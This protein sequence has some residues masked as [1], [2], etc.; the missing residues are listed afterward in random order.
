V[1]GQLD[2]RR[3]RDVADDDAIVEVERA[4]PLRAREGML[5]AGFREQQD[6]RLDRD[7]EFVEKREQESLRAR[8]R[9]LRPAV[10]DVAQQ[11][12]ATSLA[13]PPR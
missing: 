4:R 10:V 8:E 11:L 1:R 6:L 7:V 5:N 13:A 9:Q 3:T 12:V 2:E